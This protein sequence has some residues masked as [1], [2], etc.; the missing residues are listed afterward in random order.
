MGCG[1]D[2]VG[3]SSGEGDG[4]SAIDSNDNNDDDDSGGVV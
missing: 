2:G 3:C 1:I 4:G